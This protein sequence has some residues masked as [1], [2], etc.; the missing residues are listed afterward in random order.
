[1]FA[2]L[3]FA[4]GSACVTTIFA[5]SIA[6]CLGPRNRRNHRDRNR[7]S[8]PAVGGAKI[9]VTNTA[10]SAERIVTTRTRS[11]NYDLPALMPGIYDLKAEYSWF[12]T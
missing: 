1:M 7:S 8:S 12:S 3:W 5:F 6:R 4:R 2:G 10:T 9:R 11:G